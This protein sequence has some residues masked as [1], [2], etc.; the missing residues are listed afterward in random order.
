ML[1]KSTGREKI[2]QIGKE[3]NLKLILLH[4]SYATGKQ[5]KDS[6]IDIAVLGK[7]PIDSRVRAKIYSELENLFVS[8]LD[9][10]LDFKSL[11]RA[12]PFFVYKVAN[13]SALLYGRPSDYEEFKA[14]AFKLYYDS[15]DLRKLEKK[16][17]YKFQDYLNLKY[18]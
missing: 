9:K 4:G 10:E 5:R 18:A 7:K 6:D 1:L 8:G 15:E 16:M 11:H 13:E 14:Y 3:Y 17:V 2:E 12:D